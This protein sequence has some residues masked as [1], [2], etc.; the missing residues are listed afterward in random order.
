MIKLLAYACLALVIFY[1]LEAMGMIEKGKYLQGF[2][3]FQ[4][5]QEGA[6]RQSSPTPS[7]FD[8][9]LTPKSADTEAKPTKT[10]L[11]DR[12]SQ[13]TPNQPQAEPE[14]SPALEAIRA[15][16]ISALSDYLAPK[17]Q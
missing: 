10:R 1:G 2:P 7:V 3:R 16:L 5:A 4:M 6:E 17:Q 15:Q 8:R 9:W 11:S 12:A 14:R 13:N